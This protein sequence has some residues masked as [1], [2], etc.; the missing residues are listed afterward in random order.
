MD[1]HSDYSEEEYLIGCIKGGREYILKEKL[2]E[3]PKARFHQKM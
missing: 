2:E 3:L 1:M